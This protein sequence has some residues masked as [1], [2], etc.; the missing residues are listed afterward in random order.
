MLSG[1]TLAA[2]FLYNPRPRLIP[3]CRM[4]ELA[5]KR[6]ISNMKGFITI[7]LLTLITGSC[8]APVLAQGSGMEYTVYID[9]YSYSC[10]LDS[11]RVSLYDQ[12]GRIV[13]TATSPYGGEVAISFRM[14]TPTYSLTARASGHASIGSYYSWFVNGSSVISVGTGGYYW[15]SVGM[16]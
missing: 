2:S 14:S 5:R 7:V 10:S 13:G 11:V 3:V 16:H 9:F 15:I 8:V 12:A 4:H 6:L 1:T